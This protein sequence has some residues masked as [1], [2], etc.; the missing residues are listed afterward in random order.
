LPVL[1]P[2][3]GLDVRNIVGDLVEVIVGD[4]GAKHGLL[5]GEVCAEGADLVDKRGVAATGGGGVGAYCQ[6]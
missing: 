3:C 1:A 2:R 6:A 5:A 4:V